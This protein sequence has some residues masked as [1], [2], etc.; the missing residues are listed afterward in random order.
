MTEPLRSS[1]VEF[2]TDRWVS[3][4]YQ[5]PCTLCKT[6]ATKMC[7]TIFGN[8]ILDHMPCRHDSCAFRQDR[9]YL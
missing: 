5:R 8:D 2:L 1:A 9:L 7:D 3:N 4:L 6:L